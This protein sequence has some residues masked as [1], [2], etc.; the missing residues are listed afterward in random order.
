[1]WTAYDKSEKP[2]F[3]AFTLEYMIDYMREHEGEIYYV[4]K[5]PE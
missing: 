2:L 4:M 1:M 5:E 3:T